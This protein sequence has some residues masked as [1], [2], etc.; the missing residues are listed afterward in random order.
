MNQ[1][2]KDAIFSTKCTVH[3]LIDGKYEKKGA[4]YISVKNVDGKRQLIIRAATTL[5]S[6]WGN[7]LINSD[8]RWSKVKDKD[9]HLQVLRNNF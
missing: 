5:G 7:V 4:A 9:T 6:I 2:E 1:A 3:T 8:L